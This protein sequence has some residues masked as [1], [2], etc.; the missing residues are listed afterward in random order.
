MNKKHVKHTSFGG[1]ARAVTLSVLLLCIFFLSACS[2][3]TAKTSTTT[4]TNG[5]PTALPTP[6]IDAALQ[7]QGNA[8]LQTFQQWIALMQQYKGDVTTYQQQYTSDQQALQSASSS[9][10][11]KTTLNT[12]NAH[13][14]AI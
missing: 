9:A 10:A 5:E 2:G 11:Y 12:L 3:L 14:A 8:Q 1:R 4:G 13:V 6:K 7:N